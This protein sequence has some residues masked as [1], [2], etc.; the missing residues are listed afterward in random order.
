[1]GAESDAPGL[2][3]IGG[4]L[5]P[6]TLLA[7]YR[8][9]I[10][11][12]FNQGQPILWWSP[13][14]RMTLMPAQFKLHPSFRKT[15]TRFTRSAGCEVRFNSAFAEVIHACAAAPRGAQATEGH[16]DAPTRTWI[17]PAMVNAYIALHR[18]GHAHSVETWVD[19]RLAGGLYCVAVGK[20][21]FGESMFKRVT[22]ASKI[23]LAALV[24]F[25]RHHG[26]GLIDCQQNTRHLHSLGG[27]EIP[28]D[29]FLAHLETNTQEPSPSWTFDV[30]YWN[31]LLTAKPLPSSS[32]AAT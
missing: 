1:L 29:D 14:P 7:A 5:N 15:L 22:D 25:C 18:A 13:H 26:I 6:A 23:A 20:A 30:L 12:W 19:G 9:G 16:D 8:R 3:A 31:E 11:P 2:L 32:P 4:D 24:C 10:F 27:R 28:R 21:V 17:V